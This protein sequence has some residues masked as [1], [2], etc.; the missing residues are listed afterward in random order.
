M[1]VLEV[2][3]LTPL[4]NNGTVTMGDS[5]DT[6]SIPSGV[7]IANAGTATGFGGANTPAFEAY[8]SAELSVASGASVK[9]VANVERFDIGGNYDNSSNYRFTPNVAGKYFCYCSYTYNLSTTG[10]QLVAELRKNGTAVLS[11][12]HENA[13][14]INFLTNVVLGVVEFNGSSDYLEMFTSTN[15]GLTRI[16]ATNSQRVYFGAYKLIGV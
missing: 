7:T 2:N 14:N 4:A 13:G 15:S 11:G 3:K 8:P 10:I 1:S 12:N 5:G 6:I 16:L 9:V